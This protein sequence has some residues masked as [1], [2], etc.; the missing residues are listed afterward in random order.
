MADFNTLFDALQKRAARVVILP[1]A[2]PDGD[3]L[4]SSLG[5][6]AALKTLGHTVDVLSPT[7]FAD[8]FRWLPGA[9]DILVYPEAPKAV[10]EKIAAAEYVFAL[11][12]GDLDRIDD[13][14]P[15]VAQSAGTQV[16][17]DH[18]DDH[19]GFAEF[20]F[21][22]PSASSTSEMVV[23][24]ITRMGRL[25]LITP[26]AAEALY[27]GLV[28]D[29]GGFKHGPTTAA[30]HRAAALLVEKGADP[31]KIGHKIFN[32]YAPERLQFFGH[33]FRNRMTVL[34]DL[35]V[36]YIAVTAQDLIDFNIQTGGTEGLV[37]YALSVQGTNLGV[38]IIEYPER[39]KMSFRSVGS[40]PANALAQEFGGGGHY[41]A[42]GG[43]TQTSLAETEAQLLALLKG[44][45]R[46]KLNYTAYATPQPQA[47]PSLPTVESNQPQSV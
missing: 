30:V 8:F 36:A 40:F 5:L 39:I 18:H 41:N 2:R 7:A 17:L 38:L 27:T 3:A 45:F 20:T 43:A 35:K 15:I 16:N 29:T 47:G 19:K 42:A 37:N 22:D 9:D 25:D 14:G 21:A 13:L 12:Y 24:F 1:H 32:N 28:T 33:C 31:A 4:G 46:E 23:R 44:P 10:E 26:A 11:D 34:P 6:A